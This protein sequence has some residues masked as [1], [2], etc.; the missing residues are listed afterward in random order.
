MDSKRGIRGRCIIVIKRV[1]KFFNTHCLPGRQESISEV[2]A[3]DCIGRC[4]HIH[5]KRR[6]SIIFRINKWIRTMCLKENIVKSSAVRRIQFNLS[7]A[8]RNNVRYRWWNRGNGDC[9]GSGIGDCLGRGRSSCRKDQTVF[10]LRSWRNNRLRKWYDLT[11]VLPR[12]TT[13]L[14]Y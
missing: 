11:E 9:F 2:T 10:R 13:S 14:K 5:T 7:Y 3:R 8:F 6:K 12:Q 4:I 1:D